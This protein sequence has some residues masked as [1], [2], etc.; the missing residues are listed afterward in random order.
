MQTIEC[1]K[2][3]RSIR[4]YLSKVPDKSLVRSI[5]ETSLLTP[6][7]K[8]GQPWRIKIISESSQIYSISSLSIYKSWMK[9][10]PIFLAIYLDKK[11]SYNYTKDIQACGAFMQTIMLVAHDKGLGSCWIGEI[12]AQSD[13]VNKIL[14]IDASLYELM[15]IIVLGYS[16][17]DPKPCERKKIDEILL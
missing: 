2:T 17:D 3:R 13:N 9:T 7:G 14:N 8:N 1:V 5:I 4:R 11:N 16:A 12:L 6:S 10:A 15:G